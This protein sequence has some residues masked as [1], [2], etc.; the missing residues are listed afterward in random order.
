MNLR[1]INLRFGVISGGAFLGKKADLNTVARVSFGA[2]YF[3][4]L[5]ADVIMSADGIN[6]IAVKPLGK[7]V[8]VYPNIRQ[9]SAPTFF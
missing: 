5:R 9:I 4:K 7:C 3:H 8:Y 2:R 1:W 6:T